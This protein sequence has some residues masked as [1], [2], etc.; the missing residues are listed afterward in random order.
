MLLFRQ[1]RGGLAYL[2]PFVRVN[3]AVSVTVITRQ[4]P[5]LIAL[6]AAKQAAGQFAAV[7][8]VI[9]FQDLRV[10]L[11]LLIVVQGFETSRYLGKVFDALTRIQSSRLSQIIS[12]VVYLVF[13]ALA[14]PLMHF[15]GDTVKDNDLIMLAGKL[16][17]EKRTDY[18]VE[19]LGLLDC[20]VIRNGYGRQIDSFTAP[21]DLVNLDGSTEPFPA[22]FIRAPRFEQIGPGVDVL[23]RLGDEPVLLVGAS[24][25]GYLALGPEGGFKLTTLEER[26]EQG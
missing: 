20:T 6:P 18:G 5:L 21:I 15:L 22:V 12:T 26:E 17:G 3:F 14:T 8:S 16:A 11:G 9:D 13:I 25:G 23:A 19:P 7:S 24:Y 10:L 1:L 4:Q 2:F